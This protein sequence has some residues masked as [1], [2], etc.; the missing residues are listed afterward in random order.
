MIGLMVTC[1]SLPGSD[2]RPGR[3][4]RARGANNIQLHHGRVQTNFTVLAALSRGLGGGDILNIS[5]NA[6]HAGSLHPE[7]AQWKITQAI[8]EREIEKARAAREEHSGKAKRDRRVIG[9]G[10]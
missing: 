6:I 3:V 4:R 10:G 1:P 2:A 9:F 5:L 8:L 7:P